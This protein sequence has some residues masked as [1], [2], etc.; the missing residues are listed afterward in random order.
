MMVRVGQVVGQGDEAGAVRDTIAAVFRQRAYDRSI[1][2]TLWDRLLEVVFRWIQELFIAVSRSPTAKGAIAAVLIALLIALIV[3]AIVVGVGGSSPF[4]RGTARG[5]RAG[6]QGDRWAAA[7]RLAAAGQYTEAA[8]ALYGALLDSIAHR[9]RLRLHPSKTAGDYSRDLRGQSSP[10]FAPFR[11]F[12][13]SYEFV[14]Y[15]WSGCDRARY[16]R[17]YALASGMVRSGP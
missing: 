14:V 9:E 17:L 1:I 5:Q 12:A 3:R 15:G 7:Q 13:R 16:D 8:H 2:R 11:D 4:T 10:L 6:A